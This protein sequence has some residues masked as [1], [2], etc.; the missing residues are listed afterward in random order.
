MLM[1]LLCVLYLNDTF[2]CHENN[3]NIGKIRK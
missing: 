1:I 3:M 2:H